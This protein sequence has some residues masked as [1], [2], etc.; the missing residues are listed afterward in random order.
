[1]ELPVNPK[2]QNPAPFYTNQNPRLYCVFAICKNEF[3]GQ[4]SS[5]WNA[6]QLETF[7]QGS[8]SS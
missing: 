5:I 6:A 3:L 2:Y 8:L 4:C 7:A 1:M